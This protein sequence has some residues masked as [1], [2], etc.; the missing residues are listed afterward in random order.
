MK[1]EEFDQQIQE[2]IPQPSAVITGALYQM[3]VEA[4]EGRPQELLIAFEFISRHFTQD[5]LQGAY[6]IIQH[7]SAALPDELVAAAVFLQAGDTSEHMARMANDGELMCFYRPKER[8]EISPLALCTILEAGKRFDSFT[9]TFRKFS[10][11]DILARAKSYAKQHG[12]SIIG[13]FECISPEGEASGDLYAGQR[14]LAGQW[15]KMTTALSDIFGTCP[16]VAARITFDVDRDHAAVEYNPLWQKERMEHG[17][18]VHREKHQKS[19]C[20]ER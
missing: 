7:G 11:K 8:G 10:P 20:Q 6:E 14:V 2:M 13:V 16:A 1:Y 3:G 15:P 19:S 5:V 9:T 18:I 4:L 17:Q 12:K